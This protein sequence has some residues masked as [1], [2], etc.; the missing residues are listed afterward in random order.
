MQKD[1]DPNMKRLTIILIGFLLIGKVYADIAPNPIV[2]KGIYTVDSCKIQM[3]QEYVYANLYNDSAIVECTFELLNLGDSTTIQVGFPEMNFQY[4]SFGGYS[5]SD[6]RKFQIQVD[7][8]TLT[9]K[10]IKVPDEIIELYYS[11]MLID[12]INDIFRQG[13]ENIFKKYNI[14]YGKRGKRK[15]PS[16]ETRKV[17]EKELDSLDNRYRTK[18]TADVGQESS[19]YDYVSSGINPWYVWD[20]HF[21]ENEKKTIKVIYS[22]P[23]GKGYGAEYRYF[24][25]I[26]E[27]G[28]GWYGLIEK[29]DIELKL[30]D[31]N[32]ETIEEISPKGFHIDTSAKIV[33]W[34]FIDLEPTKDDDIYLRY[35]NVEERRRRELYLKKRKRAYKFR[36]INPIYWIRRI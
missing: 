16:I 28:S 35:Y 21:K 31:I 18:R 6:L 33:K 9:R 10:Q 26:L 29:A 15:Y 2:I 22:L 17:A 24:K 7:D 36:N 20:V 4:W 3:I 1:D 19:L 23:S 13:R 12:S 5:Y 25:Y 27:T 11:Y 32:M 30:H 34:N 14:T 8:T